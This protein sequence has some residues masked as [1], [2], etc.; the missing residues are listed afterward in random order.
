MKQ[1]DAIVIESYGVGGIP[2]DSKRDFL[3]EIDRLV[4][5]GKIIV[6]TT[7]VMNE[8]SDMQ[9]YAVGRVAKE[10]HGLIEAFDMTTE[11]LVTKRMWIMG[12][13]DNP[14]TIKAM[15]YTTI[16]HDIMFQG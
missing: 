8:G 13:T 6:M 16:N 2:N 3:A 10:R 11:A 9:V 4:G 7:Q 15:F 5:M 1:Y 12:Q 14:Q